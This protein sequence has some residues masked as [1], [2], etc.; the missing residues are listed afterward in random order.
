MRFVNRSTVAAASLAACGVLNR[1]NAL[2]VGAGIGEF[3]CLQGGLGLSKQV[4]NHC[5]GLSMESIDCFGDFVANRSRPVGVLF[6]Q[7]F[8]GG[9]IVALLGS[10]GG[11]G[12]E[13]ASRCCGPVRPRPSSSCSMRAVAVV[14]TGVPRP[15]CVAC[16]RAS[17]ALA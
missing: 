10:L 12:K 14:A 5:F 7:I 9:I 6:W 1:G 15:V 17:M 8:Q 16:S 11:G 13:S 2:E 4:R 3:V